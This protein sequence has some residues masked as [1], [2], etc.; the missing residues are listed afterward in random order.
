MLDS[1]DLVDV[2]A[3]AYVDVQFPWIWNNR[4][5]WKIVSDYF[6]TER[7]RESASFVIVVSLT[8]SMWWPHLLLRHVSN[9][10]CSAHVDFLCTTGLKHTHTSKGV[11]AFVGF[12]CQ[13]QPHHSDHCNCSMDNNRCNNLICYKVSWTK[14]H[15]HYLFAA[16]DICVRVRQCVWSKVNC[17]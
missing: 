17:R 5:L 3:H 8:N 2:Q 15:L 16:F 9:L 11:W 13:M 1:D 14:N 4:S 10:A 12:I 7:A 6:D